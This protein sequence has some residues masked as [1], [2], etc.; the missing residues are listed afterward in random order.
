MEEWI[1]VAHV[2][3]AARSRLRPEV[4]AW[5]AGGA[6]DEL[7]LAANTAGWERLRLRPRVLRNVSDVT[8]ACTVLGLDLASPIAVAPTSRHDI[9]DREGEVAT[10][11]GAAAAGNLMVV[12]T[13]SER[14][15]AEI[16]AATPGAPRWFQVY[17]D[18]DRSVTRE[19]VIEAAALGFGALVLTADVPVVG[20][21][22]ASGGGLVEAGRVHFDLDSTIDLESIGWLREESRL[23]VLVKGVLRSDDAELCRASGAAGVIVSNHGGRQLD[24]AVDTAHA[25]REVAAA[26]PPDFPVFVD[27]GVRLGTDVLKA[28]AL[29]ARAVFVGRPALWGLALAG[30]SGVEGV[31]RGLASELRLAMCLAGCRSL[32]EIGGDLLV[33]A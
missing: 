5:I 2:E 24:G 8:T 25:L 6:G 13:A 18:R 17:V 1:S 28:L 3:A 14:T 19:R 12:S 30:A 27:G 15:P 26:M 21:R 10:A 23:P 33:G 22:R 29:G 16:A 4:F 20:R 32:D 7:T 31:L 9:C 11:R